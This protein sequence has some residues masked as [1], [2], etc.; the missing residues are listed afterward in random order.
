MFININIVGAISASFP[1]FMFWWLLLSKN[2]GT[3]FVVCAV[4]GEPSSFITLLPA[5]IPAL[6]SLVPKI[7]LQLEPSALS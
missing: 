6:A 7:D 5:D 4:F 3:L 2:I 1:D